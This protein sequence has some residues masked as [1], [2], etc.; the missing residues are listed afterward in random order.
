M[1]PLFHPEIITI[2]A[3]IDEGNE[4]EEGMHYKR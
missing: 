1:Y 2:K 4:Q 3:E